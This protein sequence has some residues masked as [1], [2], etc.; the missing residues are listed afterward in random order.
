MACPLP[1]GSHTLPFDWFLVM[2]AD[3]L[4]ISFIASCTLSASLHKIWS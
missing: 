2:S 1:A 3:L 4:G